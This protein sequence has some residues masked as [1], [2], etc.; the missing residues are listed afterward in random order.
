MRPSNRCPSFSRIAQ[1]L[2]LGAL[3]I[4]GLGCDA[5]L[6]LRPKAPT[7]VAQAQ[8]G[9]SSGTSTYAQPAAPPPAPMSAQG[10][11]AFPVEPAPT[12]AGSYAQSG[13]MSAAN[14]PL[15]ALGTRIEGRVSKGAPRF[16]AVDLAVGDS[17]SFTMYAR[18]LHE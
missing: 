1:G 12:L 2:G 11:A 3:L 5:G 9:P 13:G 6:T 8:F 15:V 7:F 4:S 18:K 10:A 17:L 16:Y 14:A